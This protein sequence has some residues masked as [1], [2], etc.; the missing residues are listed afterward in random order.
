LISP[1]TSSDASSEPT[2]IA[3]TT[4]CF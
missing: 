2:C 1:M 3:M 4:T